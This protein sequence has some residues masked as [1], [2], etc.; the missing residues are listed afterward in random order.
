VTF[1]QCLV[2]CKLVTTNM[3]FPSTDLVR[4]DRKSSGHS[5]CTSLEVHTQEHQN[6]FVVQSNVN[7]DLG[8][9]AS[10]VFGTGRYNIWMCCGSN[11]GRVLL[12]SCSQWCTRL[13]GAHRNCWTC[14]SGQHGWMDPHLGDDLLRLCRPVQSCPVPDGLRSADQ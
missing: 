13:L 11:L 3:F 6:V 4:F 9:D 1:G 8:D 12:R 2:L 10:R 7:T 5:R 14:L